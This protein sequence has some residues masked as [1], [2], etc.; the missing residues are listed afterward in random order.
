M[1][2]NLE[3]RHRARLASLLEQ[4]AEFTPDDV[5]VALELIDEGLAHPDDPDGY[6]FIVDEEGGELRGYVCFGP[7][8]MT[9]GCFDLYWIAVDDELRG[10]GVGRRLLEAT[11][12][13]IRASGGRLLRVETA[14]LDDYAATRA[15]YERTGFTVAARIEDFY[16]E[17]NDLVIFTKRFSKR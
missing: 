1:H 11:E 3:P 10:A 9:R 7:T 16:W 8:P 12:Q 17:G 2:V 4:T 14:G 5:K 6:R 15:F 13:R